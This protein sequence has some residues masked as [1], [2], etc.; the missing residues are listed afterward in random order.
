MKKELLARCVEKEGNG[1]ERVR[2]AAEKSVGGVIRGGWF[3][4]THSVLLERQHI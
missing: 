2:R 1:G 4:S 3:T